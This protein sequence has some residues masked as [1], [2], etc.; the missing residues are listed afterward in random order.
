MV[1]EGTRIV[2]L[3][4]GHSTRQALTVAFKASESRSPLRLDHN[5]LEEG[6]IS[7]EEAVAL[8]VVRSVAQAF[9]REVALID[10]ASVVGRVIYKEAVDAARGG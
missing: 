9:G 1:G 2:G 5:G 4:V 10:I 3:E 6:S 7:R 8:L